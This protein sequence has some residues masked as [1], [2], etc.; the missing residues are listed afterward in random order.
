MFA[1]EEIPQHEPRIQDLRCTT[2]HCATEEAV[3]SAH[4]S[5]VE[6]TSVQKHVYAQHHREL[7]EGVTY[8]GLWYTTAIY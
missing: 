6:V 5:S 3:Y 4:V 7:P 2:T 1:L 8:E